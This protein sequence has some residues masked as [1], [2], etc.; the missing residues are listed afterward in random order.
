MFLWG[1]FGALLN[2]FGPYDC[3]FK[4]GENVAC[5]CDGRHEQSLFSQYE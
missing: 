5:M 4:M 1:T 3:V 2:C